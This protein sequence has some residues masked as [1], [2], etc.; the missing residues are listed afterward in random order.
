MVDVSYRCPAWREG[1]DGL[2]SQLKDI[3]LSIHQAFI[4]GLNKDLD[5]WVFHPLIF[6]LINEYF[7]PYF[8]I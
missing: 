6:N 2:F 5:Q 3:M 7:T 8:K 1:T 4:S